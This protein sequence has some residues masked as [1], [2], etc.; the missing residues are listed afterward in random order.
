VAGVDVVGADLV[1]RHPQATAPQRGHQAGGHGGLAVARAG[2][3]DDQAGLAHHSM[4]A[5]PL[6][7]ASMGCLTLV[8][9][10]TRS[11]ASISAG[12]ARRPVM[13]TCWMPGRAASTVSTSSTS[14]VPL[15]TG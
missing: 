15:L 9:S 1:R 6:R 11:A 13:T 10:V 2:A 3:G 5:C 7:P 4:P 12:W 14:R 8:M